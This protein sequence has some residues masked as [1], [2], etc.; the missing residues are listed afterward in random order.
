MPSAFYDAELESRRLFHSPPFGS[1]VKLTVALDDRS[2]AEAKGKDLV[3]RLRE[4]ASELGADVEV[5]G[6]VPAYI[7]R[8]AGKWRFHVVLRGDR[9]LMSWAAIRAYL[10][11]LTWTQ[12]ASSE[13][14]RH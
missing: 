1:L 12:K 13:R 14:S 3:A 7:A 2:A 11:P 10:G 6:P 8:R 5:L 9:P 4:R